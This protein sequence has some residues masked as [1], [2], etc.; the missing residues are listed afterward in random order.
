MSIKITAAC[1]DCLEEAGGRQR[2]HKIDWQL[3]ICPCCTKHTML[4]VAENFGSP[5]LTAK[6]LP[7]TNK[8]N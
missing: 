2:K 4:T 6:I 5:K 8:E 1:A 7:I 3:D